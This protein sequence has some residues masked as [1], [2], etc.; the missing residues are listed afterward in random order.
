[1]R[2]NGLKVA[3]VPFHVKACVAGVAFR[4]AATIHAPA[5]GRAASTYKSDFAGER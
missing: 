2:T 5:V 3:A 1:M 4:A